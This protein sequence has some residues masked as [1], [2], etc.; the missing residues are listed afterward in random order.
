MKNKKFRTSLTIAACLVIATL[1][2]IG[3]RRASG[4]P[5]ETTIVFDVT[6][7]GGAVQGDRIAFAYVVAVENARRKGT[8]ETALPDSTAGQRRASAL[9]L[10]DQIIKKAHNDNEQLGRKSIRHA[11]TENQQERIDRAT[12]ERLTGGEAPESIVTDIE[13]GP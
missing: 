11:F 5:H 7:V 8:V 1:S 12:R 4:G 9:I 2:I 13:A 6:A 3:V 10:Y